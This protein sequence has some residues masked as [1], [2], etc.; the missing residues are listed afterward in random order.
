MVFKNLKWKKSPKK[1]INFPNI[2]LQ[3]DFGNA[4]KDLVCFQ[5]LESFLHST[6]EETISDSKNI[7]HLNILVIF[8]HNWF[9]TIFLMFSKK[10]CTVFLIFPLGYMR[11][12]AVDGLCMQWKTLFPLFCLC[13]DDESSYYDWFCNCFFSPL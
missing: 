11:N 9:L 6:L 12:W 3:T 2:T 5:F 10:N 1:Q 13:F 7:H 4:I 8:S